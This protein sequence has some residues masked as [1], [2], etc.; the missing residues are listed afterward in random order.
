MTAFTDAYFSR[1]GWTPSADISIDTL[2]ALHLHHNAAIPFENLDVLLN[3]EILLD[4]PALEAKLVQ[5]RRGGYCFEQNGLFE[6][7]LSTLGFE[8]RSLLARVVLSGPQQMPPLTHRVLLVSLNG[9]PWLADVGFGSQTLTAPIRLREEETQLTPHGAYRLQREGDDWILAFKHHDRWQPMYRFDLATR[10]FSD[11]Q[12]GNFWSANWPA[13]HFR[14]HL[15]FSRHLADGS[16]LT[17][18]NYLFTHWK[19]EAEVA[20]Q[21]ILP[22]A[23]ALRQVLAN[24]FG[25]AV[26]DPR[27]GVSLDELATVVPH[28][29][30]S[31]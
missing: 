16:K 1:L 20:E 14:H 13:S 27:H 21:Q 12:M 9:E 6:R 10:Y 18:N 30:P 17:L 7:V 26:D 24:R 8:V 29:A 2:R 19:A 11:Y 22:D 3:R 23:S 28:T 5:G 25:L 4:D 31:Q 15:I